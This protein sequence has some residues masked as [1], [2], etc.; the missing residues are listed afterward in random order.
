VPVTRI[1]E[2]YKLTQEEFDEIV[3]TPFFQRRLIEELDLWN[4][5]DAGNIV[6]RIGAKSAT[7]VEESLPEIFALIHDKV[8]PMQAKIDA[9]KTVSRWAGIGN[10]NPNV[11]GSPDDTGVK[12]TINIGDQ[13]LSFEKERALQATVIEGDVVELTPDK[14]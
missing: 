7:M 12:I 11:R 14:T 8:Q 1:R 2:A 13:K 4:S 10:E 9:L 5:S 3:E 6:K